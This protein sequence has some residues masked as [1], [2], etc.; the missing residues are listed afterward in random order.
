MNVI[1]IIA[2][3][4]AIGDPTPLETAC[5]HIAAWPDPTVGRLNLDFMGTSIKFEMYI[6][7]LQS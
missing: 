4:A 5:T 7:P 3:A 2:A 1:R 6:P